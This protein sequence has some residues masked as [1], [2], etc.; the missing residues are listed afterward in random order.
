[1]PHLKDG[2]LYALLHESGVYFTAKETDDWP[3][4]TCRDPSTSVNSKN[5]QMF[6]VWVISQN[7]YTIRLETFGTGRA[8]EI[9]MEHRADSGVMVKSRVQGVRPKEAEWIVKSSGHG[10]YR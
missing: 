9:V 10:K 1:M 3:F 4:V 6:I 7:P 2:G 5:Y 8:E